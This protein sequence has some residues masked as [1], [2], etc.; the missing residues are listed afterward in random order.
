MGSLALK[1]GCNYTKVF[2]EVSIEVLV[3]RNGA[4]I[5]F[6]YFIVRITQLP[7]P[8]YSFLIPDCYIVHSQRYILFIHTFELTIT[9]EEC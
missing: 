7:V 5:K 3:T 8:K 1:M 6:S 2:D 4:I 9:F